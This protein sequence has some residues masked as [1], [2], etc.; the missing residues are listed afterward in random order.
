MSMKTRTDFVGYII[1]LLIIVVMLAF[2]SVLTR[3]DSA[4]SRAARAEAYAKKLEQD[5]RAERTKSAI[6]MANYERVW[7]ELDQRR[8]REAKP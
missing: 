2:R 1:A 6:W 8:K 7:K 3:A 5:I 4:E